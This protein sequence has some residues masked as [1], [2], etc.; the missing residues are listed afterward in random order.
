MHQRNILQT[1][2]SKPSLL[3]LYCNPT[4]ALFQSLLLPAFRYHFY[5]CMGNKGKQQLLQHIGGQYI[6]YT[7]CCHNRDISQSSWIDAGFII[8]QNIFPDL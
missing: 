3:H 7:L 1:L 2:C 4:S 8:L 5:C 6:P